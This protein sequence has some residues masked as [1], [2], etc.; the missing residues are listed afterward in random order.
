MLQSSHVSDHRDLRDR[1]RA[2]LAG[3]S[4]SYVADARDFAPL[5]LDYVEMLS[6]LTTTQQRCSELLAENRRLRMAN[7]SLRQELE[8]RK[9]DP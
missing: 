6:N 1:A 2:L 8:N 9:I 4:R 7:E 3:Q 5:V